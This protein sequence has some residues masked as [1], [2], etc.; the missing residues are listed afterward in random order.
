MGWEASEQMPAILR[1]SDVEVVLGNAE[2]NKFLSSIL[3]HFTNRW[4]CAAEKG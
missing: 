4:S 2:V 1:Q 3:I